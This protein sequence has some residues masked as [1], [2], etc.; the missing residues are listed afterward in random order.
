MKVSPWPDDGNQPSTIENNSA[1]SIADQKFGIDM[2]TTDS[3]MPSRSIRCVVG[4]RS[5]AQPQFDLAQ[6]IDPARDCVAAG[7]RAHTSRRSRVDQ[8]PRL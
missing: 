1:S 6:A 2:A 4:Q 5:S 3:A 8:I 7:N